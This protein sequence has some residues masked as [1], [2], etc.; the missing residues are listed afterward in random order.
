MGALENSLRITNV[1]KDGEKLEHLC[2]ES[3]NVK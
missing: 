2:T 1:A 3:S